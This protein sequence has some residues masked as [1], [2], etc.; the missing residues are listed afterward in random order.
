M[1]HLRLRNIPLSNRIHVCKSLC[2][3]T[4]LEHYVMDLEHR[5]ES[6]NSSS[7][8]GVSDINI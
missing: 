6:N 8:H 1:M 2:Y 3:H 7:M 5:N 4:I